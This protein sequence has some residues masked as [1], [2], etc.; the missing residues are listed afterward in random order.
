[1]NEKDIINFKMNRYYTKMY[2]C[3]ISSVLGYAVRATTTYY[4]LIHFLEI[5]ES[6][7]RQ[8]TYSQKFIVI[9]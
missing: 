6:I 1:M 2:K 4:C 5:I 3:N 7:C 9:I 8:T